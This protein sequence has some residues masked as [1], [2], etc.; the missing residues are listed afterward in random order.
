MTTEEYDQKNK[1][2]HF[3]NFT[4]PVDHKGTQ[5]NLNSR[6]ELRHMDEDSTHQL[7]QNTLLASIVLCFG[8][9]RR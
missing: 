1:K 2:S 6:L 5:S 9:V 8:M 4:N 7:I 3:L